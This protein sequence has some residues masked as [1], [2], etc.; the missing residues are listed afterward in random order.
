MRIENLEDHLRAKDMLIP[1]LKEEIRRI[2]LWEG[3][4]AWLGQQIRAPE[5][6]EEDRANILKTYIPDLRRSDWPSWKAGAGKFI[7]VCKPKELPAIGWVGLDHI[8]DDELF[9][10]APIVD[11]LERPVGVWAKG[12]QEA[13]LFPRRL[14]PKHRTGYV[15]FQESPRSPVYVANN[16]LEVL[17]HSLAASRLSKRL[18][19]LIPCVWSHHAMP[20]P[21]CPPE[22][23]VPVVLGRLNDINTMALVMAKKVT[24]YMEV[25]GNRTV[26]NSFNRRT[27]HVVGW[28]EAIVSGAKRQGSF[29]RAWAVQIGLA[30][31]EK[32][33]PY[34]FLQKHDESLFNELANGSMFVAS[35]GDRPVWARREG[36]YTKTLDGAPVLVTNCI[37]KITSIYSNNNQMKR[38]ECTG[39][40]DGR[41]VKFIVPLEYLADRR[42][43]NTLA[44]ECLSQTRR[45]LYCADGSWPNRLGRLILAMHEPIETEGVSY[46]WGW[47]EKSLCYRIGKTIITKNGEIRYYRP[48]TKYIPDLES[49]K[50]DKKWLDICG[51]KTPQNEMM[52]ASAALICAILMSKKRRCRDVDRV[53]FIA[54][55]R[56]IARKLPLAILGLKKESDNA[57]MQGWPGFAAEVRGMQSR[58]QENC[59]LRIV[60]PETFN[61][62]RLHGNRW[63]AVMA[64]GNRLPSKELEKAAARLIP[65]WLAYSVKEDNKLRSTPG[66]ASR[67][68]PMIILEDMAKWF[69]SLGGN[70]EVI[71]S[72]ARLIKCHNE[73]PQAVAYKAAVELMVRMLENK[74]AEL[75]DNYPGKNERD[76]E[77]GIVIWNDEGRYILNKRGFLDMFEYKAGLNGRRFMHRMI[78]LGVLA[79]E[80]KKIYEVELHPD[81]IKEVKAQSSLSSLCQLGSSGS[82][83]SINLCEGSLGVISGTPSLMGQ[84]PVACQSAQ[85]A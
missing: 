49:F 3:L 56:R 39:T 84:D 47:H 25:D 16:A 32:I 60:S 21:Y 23:E 27:Y 20:D 11:H 67:A 13:L 35:Y 59:R 70:S 44:D 78:Q 79:G 31:N 5:P 37:A 34:A 17:N 75:R 2:E 19:P 48:N 66:V 7:F 46:V 43:H 52:W 18:P 65:G 40:I 62:S 83:S 12:M 72:S 22:H 54:D 68:L 71:N 81:F 69:A 51:L 28:E 9:I 30:G 74:V 85:Q 73:T 55:N 50:C 63:W 42:F 57:H 1:N 14:E 61:Y 77:K 33:S 26:I 6:E 10:A 80:S 4:R 64:K 15:F 29:L 45:A 24:T 58:K 53:G 76:S 8:G 36:I 41:P 38:A 82:T